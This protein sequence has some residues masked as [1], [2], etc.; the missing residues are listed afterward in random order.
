MLDDEKNNMFAIL[1]L[2]YT[3]GSK[4]MAIFSEHNSDFTM[5][6]DDV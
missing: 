6:C 1:T 3:V 2:Q 4:T 5:V